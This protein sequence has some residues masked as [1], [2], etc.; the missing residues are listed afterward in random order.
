MNERNELMKHY[1]EMTKEE[2]AVLCYRLGTQHEEWRTKATRLKK[3]EN[4]IERLNQQFT[5]TEVSA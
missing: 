2:L 4:V 3:L 1:M 5:F